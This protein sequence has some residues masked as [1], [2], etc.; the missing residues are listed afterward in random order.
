MGQKPIYPN[1]DLPGEGKSSTQNW[2]PN[3]LDAIQLVT[4]LE[5]WLDS[6]KKN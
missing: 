5:I 2:Q 6:E 4:E 3:S 1:P